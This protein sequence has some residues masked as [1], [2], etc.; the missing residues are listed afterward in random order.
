MKYFILLC[1][2]FVVSK[3]NGQLL[4]INDLIQIIKSNE[5]SSEIILNSKKRLINILMC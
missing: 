5:D 3:I 1:S 2:L 4:S